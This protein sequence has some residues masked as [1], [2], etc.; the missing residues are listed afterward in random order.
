[1]RGEFDAVIAPYHDVGMTAI[2]GHYRRVKTELVPDQDDDVLPSRVHAIV[3]VSELHRPTLRAIAFARASRP[4]TLTALTVCVSPEETRALAKDWEARNIR[5]PLKVIDSPFREVTRPVLDYLARSR[6]ECPRDLFCIYIPE[7]VV[8]N[9]WANVLHNQTSLRLKGRL[10]FE[11][12]VMV[13]SVP[14][15]LSEGSNAVARTGV[16]QTVDTSEYIS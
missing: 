13:T 12:R 2:N 15:Q 14:W 16:I 10:L 7:Y 9:W 3:L 4:D 11:P 1:M 5:I 6:S 8:A